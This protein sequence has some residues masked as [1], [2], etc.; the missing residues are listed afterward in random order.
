MH[1]IFEADIEVAGRTYP[2]ALHYPSHFPSTPPKVLPRGEDKERWSSH[3]FGAGGEL[4]LEFG[5]DNWTP[6][7][8][9]VQL[10][11]SAHRLLSLEA[12]DSPAVQ[13]IPSRHVSTLGQELRGAVFRLI[14][15]G[16]LLTFLDTVPLGAIL[17]GNML[18]SFRKTMPDD[19]SVTGYVDKVTVTAEETWRD[20]SIPSPLTYEL[21]DSELII[22]RVAADA[23]AIST[24]TL[25]EF[26]GGCA[27]LGLP[28]VARNLILLRGDDVAAHYVLRAH[29]SMGSFRLVPAFPGERRLSP[30]HDRLKD[31]TVGLIGCGSLGSKLATILARCGV[32]S[33][34]LIDDDVLQPGNLVRNELDWRDMGSHKVDAVAR[35][36]FYV[37][38]EVKV[39]VKRIQLAGQESSATAESALDQIGGCD[40]IIDATANPDVLNLVS[41]VAATAKKPSLWAEVFGGGIGG[42]IAR[43][44]PGKEPPPQ[45]MRRAIENWFGEQNA[46]PVRATR[47]YE[48]GKKDAPLIAD[49]ADVSSIAAAAARLAIDT[50]LDT[51]PS[52]FPHSAYAIGLAPGSVFS[53]PLQNF[54]IDV[55]ALAEVEA[56]P[57][58]S[59]EE[60]AAEMAEI[61]K[62]FEPK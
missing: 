48:T 27:A 30:E 62:L 34:V 55:G 53:Q 23:P 56:S 20:N 41:A 52:L 42:L 28:E 24:K 59:Q 45:Y 13:A 37:N 14:V 60:T 6:D 32:G 4:C 5:P 1:F 50:L 26:D 19:L 11:E 10:L 17:S 31:K 38:P 49:D 22:A 54:P 9:G 36:L 35:H 57:T 18:K 58:L 25:A 51:S 7:M 40:L 44:R 15:T 21:N 8:T 3:Q 2:V 33:F 47:N 12:G 39:R 43:C 46:T 61:M 16:N 29:N